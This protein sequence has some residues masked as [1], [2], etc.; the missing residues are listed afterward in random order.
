LAVFLGAL[1]IGVTIGIAMQPECPEC[2][3]CPECPDVSA[4]PTIEN[5]IVFPGVMCSEDL[6]PTVA[7]IQLPEI[8]Q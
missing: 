5:N 8:Q 6:P 7:C 3:Q 4:R 1:A 2:P